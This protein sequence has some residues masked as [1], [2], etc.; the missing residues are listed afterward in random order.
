MDV[1]ELLSFQPDVPT[2]GRMPTVTG[3]GLKRKRRFEDVD[4]RPAQQE[5]A[6]ERKT[7][8][9]VSKEDKE[10]I[11]KLIDEEPEVEAMDEGSLKRLLLQFEKRVYRN[12]EMRIK[13]PDMPGKFMSSELE[14]NDTLQEM[15]VIA[16]VPDLYPVLV[17]LS[18]IQS[19]LQ[20]ISHDNTDVSI[21][22]VDLIQEMTDVDTLNESEEGANVLIDALLAGQVLALLV[23]NLE[24]L[25]ES[26]KEESDGVHNT[27]NI[28]ENMTELR[29]ETCVDATKQ[30]FMAWLLKR[31]KVTLLLLSD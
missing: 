17:D 20:L 24:R 7:T 5:M 30:G 13:Y 9:G 3:G 1:N 15:H 29:P 25:D 10:K 21:A 12:Q 18:A 14:L 2:P 19:L 28:V 23:Q 22:V 6:R 16:T 4:L 8:F 11:L 27:L 26:I 31:I